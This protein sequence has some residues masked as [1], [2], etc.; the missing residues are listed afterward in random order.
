MGGP[1]PGVS[2]EAG[3]ASREARAFPHGNR[4]GPG[5]LG[6]GRVLPRQRGGRHAAGLGNADGRPVSHMNNRA[7]H[8]FAVSDF[9]F[10][11]QAGLGVLCRPLKRE[12]VTA[13]YGAQ[14]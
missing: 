14:A 3:G 2:R 6:R 13:A 9:G 4:S 5:Q 7:V 1:A 11:L 12:I 8:G 10:E